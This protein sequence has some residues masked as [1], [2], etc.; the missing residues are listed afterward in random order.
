V[1]VEKPGATGKTDIK[2]TKG[3]S[4][5]GQA[6]DSAGKPVAGAKVIAFSMS[7]A[8]GMRMEGRFEGDAGAVVTDEQGK[9]KLEH[10]GT[11]DEKLKV[12]SE[13]FAPRIVEN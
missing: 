1:R 2:V 4:L 8:I 6:V 7:K 11:G 3:G 13:R 9:F 5:S 10:L 12:V